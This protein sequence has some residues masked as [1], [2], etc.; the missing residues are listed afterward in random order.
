MI[1]AAGTALEIMIGNIS[2]EVERYTAIRVPTV[3]TRPEK[4]LEAAAENPHCGIT[5]RSPPHTGP[6]FPAVRI[7]LRAT[8]PV[9]CSSHSIN[10]YVR[11][12]NGSNFILSITESKII[13]DIV[14]VPPYILNRLQLLFL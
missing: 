3:S 2:S 5:P 1:V 8:E 12:R 10:K 7:L 13:S 9:L 4:R 14:I 6:N 11:K